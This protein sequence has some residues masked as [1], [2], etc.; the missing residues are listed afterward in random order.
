[1]HLTAGNQ[2]ATANRCLKESRAEP[3]HNAF[4]SMNPPPPTRSGK[5]MRTEHWITEAGSIAV[6]SIDAIRC[7]WAYL[8][9]SMQDKNTAPASMKQTIDFG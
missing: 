9:S 1:M 6:I 5:A 7:L 4:A 2:T 3:S 8:M